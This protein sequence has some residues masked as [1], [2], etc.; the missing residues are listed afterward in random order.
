MYEQ[1]PR[2]FRQEM[3]DMFGNLDLDTISEYTSEI[4]NDMMDSIRKH[5]VRCMLGTCCKLASRS[6]LR[7][8]AANVDPQQEVHCSRVLLAELAGRCCQ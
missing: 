6:S 3:S 7:S 4:I 1:D 2:A 5:Q 8:S